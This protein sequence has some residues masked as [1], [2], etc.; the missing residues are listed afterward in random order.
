VPA[1]DGNGIARFLVIVREDGRKLFEDDVGRKSFRAVVEP[2]F[3]IEGIIVTS[4]DGI[5]PFP[6][7]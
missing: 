3:R 1:I 4:T 2:G 5:V 7:T 6:G